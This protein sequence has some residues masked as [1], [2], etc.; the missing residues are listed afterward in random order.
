MT[1]GS[2]EGI[3]PFAL[4]EPGFRPGTSRKKVGRLLGCMSCHA[5]RRLAVSTIGLAACADTS[6]TTAQSLI[7]VYREAE[8]LEPY[9]YEQVHTIS[10]PRKYPIVAAAREALMSQVPQPAECLLSRLEH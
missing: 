5:R 9:Y 7:D 6:R 8:A 3:D 1:D 2:G 4:V 10:P